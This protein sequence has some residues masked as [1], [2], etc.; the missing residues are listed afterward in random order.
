MV[1]KS[2]RDQCSMSSILHRQGFRA[3]KPLKS[4]SALAGSAAWSAIVSHGGQMH[5]QPSGGFY[6]IFLMNGN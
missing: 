6:Y 1:N 4:H 5:S 3:I 2:S